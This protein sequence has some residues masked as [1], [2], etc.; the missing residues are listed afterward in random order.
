MVK[1]II[2]EKYENSKKEKIKITHTPLLKM[3]LRTTILQMEHE[4]SEERHSPISGRKETVLNE[5]SSQNSEDKCLIKIKKYIAL[6]VV[7]DLS[8]QFLRDYLCLQRV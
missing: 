2:T 1:F 6:F 7:Y 8:P 3:I 4:S 5:T